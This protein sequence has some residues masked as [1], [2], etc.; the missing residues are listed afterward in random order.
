MIPHTNTSLYTDQPYPKPWERSRYLH[1]LVYIDSR[2]AEKQLGCKECALRMGTEIPGCAEH[3]CHT[4][5]WVTEIEAAVM[6]MET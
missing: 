3:P 2:T 4:G 6:R 1:T 5:I